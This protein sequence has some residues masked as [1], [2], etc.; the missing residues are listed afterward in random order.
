[1]EKA[2][3]NFIWPLPPHI[4]LTL[5]EALQLL[6][7]IPKSIHFVSL[8]QRSWR[9]SALGWTSLELGGQDYS[10]SDIYEWYSITIR[11]YFRRL[12]QLQVGLQEFGITQ[13]AD[14]YA[15]VK[16]WGMKIMW[17]RE[18]ITDYYSKGKRSVSS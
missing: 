15:R 18:G 4:S 10:V 13:R 11:L 5:F 14:V 1:M 8:V 9:K 3:D 6:L 12:R 16:G 2:Q 7:F 17:G